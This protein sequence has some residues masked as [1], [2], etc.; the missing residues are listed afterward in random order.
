MKIRDMSDQQLDQ[1]ARAVT[2]LIVILRN[3]GLEGRPLVSAAESELRMIEIE[4][5]CRA[6]GLT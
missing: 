3:E 4:T 6:E 2:N 5:E 1:A